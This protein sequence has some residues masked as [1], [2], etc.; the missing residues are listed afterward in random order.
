MTTT[1]EFTAVLR[2][3]IG[4]TEPPCW[5]RP[6]SRPATPGLPTQRPPAGPRG[7]QRGRHHRVGT[8][9]HP[10]RRERE[11]QHQRVIVPTGPAGPGHR[12]CSSR[13]GRRRGD[14]SRSRHGLPHQPFRAGRRAGCGGQRWERLAR[15]GRRRPAVG[16]RYPAERIE[17]HRPAQ[18]ADGDREGA[19][20]PD[21]PATPCWATNS[22][23][24]ACRSTGP[25]MALH[26]PSQPKRDGPRLPPSSRGSATPTISR[27]HRR[28]G[29]CRFS[30]SGARSWAPLPTRRSVIVSRRLSVSSMRENRASGLKGG[31][32]TRTAQGTCVPDD[33]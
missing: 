3:Q 27:N 16:G 8:T 23:S 26:V 15:G 4:T 2:D 13:R 17:A 19:T 5:P 9:G 11:L 18:R 21:S 1:S 28:G 29:P 6:G 12:K 30:S 14:G 33:Q 25:K 10:V 32:G 7:P 20:V 22:T 31:W 24:P